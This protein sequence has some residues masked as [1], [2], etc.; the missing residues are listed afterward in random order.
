MTTKISYAVAFLLGLGLIFL[1][2]RFF[3]NPE[4]A[5]AA[6][7]IHL[8]SNGDYSFHYTKGIRDIFSG[9]LLCTFVIM[10]QRKAVGVTL[11]AGAL[12]PIVDMLIVLSKSYTGVAQALSHMIA[13]FLCSVFGIILL[14]TKPKNAAQ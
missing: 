6:F 5:T 8:N 13:I 14:A 9:I 12:I 2:A 4:A 7:G 11:L 10:N 1:G 3:F